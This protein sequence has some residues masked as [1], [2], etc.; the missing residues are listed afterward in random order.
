VLAENL[1][2]SLSGL[3]TI[4]PDVVLVTLDFPAWVSDMVP[5]LLAAGVS[6]P[7]LLLCSYYAFPDLDDLV[8]GGVSGVVSSHARLEELAESL[9]ALADDH[10]DPLPLQYLRAARSET[11]GYSKNILS[12]RERE[13][14]QL[15]AEDFTDQEIA[16]RLAVSVHTVHNHLRHAYAQ[17]GVRGR[18][19]AV[20][21]GIR[22]GILRVPGSDASA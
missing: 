14:L 21:A 10:P 17:L 5:A 13:V 1:D 16:R 9:Y 11:H 12:D 20:G 2:A 7:V 6:A 8:A 4:A 15:V 3:E 19:G 22:R 18:G